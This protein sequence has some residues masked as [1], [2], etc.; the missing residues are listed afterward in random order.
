MKPTVRL[1]RRLTPDA[2]AYRPVR[3]D[4]PGRRGGVRRR[5]QDHT[6]ATHPDPDGEVGC[7]DAVRTTPVPPTPTRTAR[8]VAPTRSGPHPC[9]PPRPPTPTARWVVSGGGRGRTR[10]GA[11][12]R[13]RRG[14]RGPPR[15]RG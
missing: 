11:R 4:A 9:H 12:H 7:A 14:R 13:A 2:S 5:G 15:G 1:P 3:Q 10:A 8:W 6:R